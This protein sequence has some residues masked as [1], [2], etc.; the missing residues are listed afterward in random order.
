MTCT[1]FGHTYIAG[2]YRQRLKE[3]IID[4]I[5][6]HGVD[7]FYV[8]H[9]GSFDR[10]A[11]DILSEISEDFDIDYVVV[12]SGMPAKSSTY[13]R[14]LSHHSQLPDGI[15]KV[16]PKFRI[17][18]RNEWMI[19]NSDYVI[20]YINNPYGTGAARFAELAEKKG[21]KIIKLGDY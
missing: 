17:I 13:M 21:K 3:V 8:G 10:T 7:K 11:I 16:L 2:D 5:E 12:L 20:T 1:F 6:N 18:Y 19:K 9:H 4:L 15:E 14:S